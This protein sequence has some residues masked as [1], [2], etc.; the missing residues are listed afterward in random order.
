MPR[1]S[2]FSAFHPCKEGIKVETVNIQYMSIPTKYLAICPH[3]QRLLQHGRLA[4]ECI[5]N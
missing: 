1:M 5:V 3:Q 2:Q 4:G